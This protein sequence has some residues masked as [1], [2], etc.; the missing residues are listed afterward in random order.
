MIWK[1]QRLA[2]CQ[3]NIVVVLIHCSPK[4]INN[5]WLL[6]VAALDRSWGSS[7]PTKVQSPSRRRPVGIFPDWKMD[8]VRLLQYLGTHLLTGKAS[9]YPILC[10]MPGWN[11]YVERCRRTLKVHFREYSLLTRHREC[12]I[13][14][15]MTRWEAVS[16]PDQA[17][18]PR[19]CVSCCLMNIYRV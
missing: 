13:L 7:S 17:D 14:T 2:R 8:A 3:V 18:H 16:K 12:N 10:S 5:V 19:G 11:P 4:R 6:T 15:R 9:E 1:Q